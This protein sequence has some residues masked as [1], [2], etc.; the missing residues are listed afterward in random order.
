VIRL[1]SV[2][3]TFGT[4]AA[5]VAALDGISLSVAAGEFV[6]LAGPSGSGKTSLLHL[7]GA[8]DHPTSGRVFVDGVDL[9]TLPESGRASL[10]L[11]RIGFVFQHFNLVPV[12]SAAENVELPLLFRSDLAPRRRRDR[13]RLALERVGLGPARDR[14]PGELSGGEQQRVAVARALAG[15]PALILADEPTASLDHETGGAV[16]RL[17]RELNRER[18]TTFLYSSHDPEL[19]GLADRVIRLRDG[20][21]PP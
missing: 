3:R 7:V 2:R 17:M 15:E 19:V 18:G 1:E 10:R 4:G 8:I 11:R 9:A 5:S 20:R 6:A 13:A 16:V 21:I 12:L 14:R